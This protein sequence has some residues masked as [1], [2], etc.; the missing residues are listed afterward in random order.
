[1]TTSEQPPEAGADRRTSPLVV[2]DLRMLRRW[3]AVMTAIALIAVG[4]AVYAVI[5]AND[6]A[7]QERV[8]VLENALSERFQGDLDEEAQP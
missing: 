4:V 6:S 3:L 2:E 7:D 5:K 8:E 1:M